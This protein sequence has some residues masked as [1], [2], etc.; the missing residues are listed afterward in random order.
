MIFVGNPN[1]ILFY[2]Y[3]GGGS[4]NASCIMTPPRRPVASCVGVQPA[5]RW[6]RLPVGPPSICLEIEPYGG[7]H[8]SFVQLVADSEWK[9]LPYITEFI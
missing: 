7:V 4:G 1:F 6:A 8:N 9:E 3:F 5:R 2:I